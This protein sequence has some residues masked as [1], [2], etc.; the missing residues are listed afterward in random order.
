M[1]YNKLR[2]DDFGLYLNALEIFMGS[3]NVSQASVMTD[4]PPSQWAV[5]P[6]LSPACH[7]T[8]SLHKLHLS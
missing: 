2:T 3:T 5:V 8:P 7:F 6:L 1:S 4:W